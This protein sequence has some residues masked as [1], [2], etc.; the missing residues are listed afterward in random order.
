MSKE[1]VAAGAAA[2]AAMNLAGKHSDTVEQAKGI[3]E[4]AKKGVK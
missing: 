2:V 3:V 1:A 4:G